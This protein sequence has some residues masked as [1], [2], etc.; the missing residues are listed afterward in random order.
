MGYGQAITNDFTLLKDNPAV[1]VT[2]L[3]LPKST[4]EDCCFTIQV[5]AKL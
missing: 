2:V 3:D 4:V 1:I 5:L